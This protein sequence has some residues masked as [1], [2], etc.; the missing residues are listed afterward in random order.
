MMASE[1]ISVTS[2][3]K[4]LRA[5]SN[6]EASLL[7]E[8]DKLK[9]ELDEAREQ[10]DEAR[11]KIEKLHEELECHAWTISPA[12]AQAKIDALV[13]QRDRLAEAL[14]CIAK[15]SH[16]LQCYGGNGI[17]ITEQTLAA[18]KGGQP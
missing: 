2:M 10:R 14:R 4:V 1:H 13:E 11:S 5:V 15:G 7:V 8:R 12:M 3:C 6:R 18:A 9:R 16:C 17:W